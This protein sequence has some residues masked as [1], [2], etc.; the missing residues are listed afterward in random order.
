MALTILVFSR[1][2]NFS[3]RSEERRVGKEC[4]SRW[5]LDHQKKNYSLTLNF[6]GAT[7]PSTPITVV[8]TLHGTLAAGHPPLPFDASLLNAYTSR[9]PDGLQITLS[10]TS[11]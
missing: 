1:F 4:R 6:S 9:V 2:N 3:I 8:P 5:S 10:L 11:P 7:C